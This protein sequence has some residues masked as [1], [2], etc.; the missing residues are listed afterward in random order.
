MFDAAVFLHDEKVQHEFR[1]M[2]AEDQ[3][4]APLLPAQQR[5]RE[6]ASGL[7]ENIGY[8]LIWLIFAVQHIVSNNIIRYSPSA[9]R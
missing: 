9:S 1:L 5:V 8:Q 4:S 7:P 6:A 3:G 2:P